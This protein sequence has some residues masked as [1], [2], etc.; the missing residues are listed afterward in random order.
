MPT[1]KSALR[2]GNGLLMR[3][4]APKV[5]MKL[6]GPH[7]KPGPMGSHGAGMKKGSVEFTL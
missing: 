7:A 2:F 4:S 1:S 6:R 5:P 3:I